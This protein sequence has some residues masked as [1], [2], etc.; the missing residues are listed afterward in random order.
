MHP[1]DQSQSRVTLNGRE[2]ELAELAFLAQVNY[3]HFTS[4]QVRNRSARGFSLH[5]QRLVEATR[6][7]FGTEL[8]V[9]RLRAQVRHILEADEAVSLRITVFSLALDREH[10]ERPVAVDVL[11]ATRAVRTSRTT[12]LRVQSVRHDRDLP[13]LKHAG[14]FA[15]FRHWRQAR[16]A[17][18][19]DAVFTTAAGDISEGSIWNIGFWDGERVIWPS[20]PA[21]PGITLQLLDAGL[22]AQGIE[23]SVRPVHLDR[24]GDF[25]CAFAMNSGSVGPLIESIDEHRFQ[26]DPDFMLQLT[27]AYETQPLEPV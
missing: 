5:V 12:P 3:G 20:A 27:A 22:R 1:P 16:L 6:E 23:T 8:D 25:R 26:M 14:T 18:Y 9:D 15:L 2:P 17:G 13:H 19:D 10:L 4:L 7:L 21:L 11:L 24:L